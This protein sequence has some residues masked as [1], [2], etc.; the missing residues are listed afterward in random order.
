MAHAYANSDGFGLRLA[1]EAE[2]K[3]MAG[4]DIVED[5]I[6]WPDDNKVSASLGVT[7]TDKKFKACVGFI[8]SEFCQCENDTNCDDDKACDNTF[9]VSCSCDSQHDMLLLLSRKY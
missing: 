3:L 6:G 9:K 8:D 2:L 7:V 5:L 1:F 4:F